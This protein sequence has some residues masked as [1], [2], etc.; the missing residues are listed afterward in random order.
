MPAEFEMFAPECTGLENCVSDRQCRAAAKTSLD[1][2]GRV[3]ADGAV[4]DRQRRAAGIAG[5][6]DACRRTVAELPLMVLLVIVSVALPEKP[7][8]M[9]P[10][11]CETARVAADGAVGDRQRRAAGI[12]VVPDAAAAADRRVAADGAVGDRQRRAAA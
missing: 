8:F 3:A 7:L 5:V 10:P 6:E 2:V 9:M 4:G 12:A 1:A 11:P